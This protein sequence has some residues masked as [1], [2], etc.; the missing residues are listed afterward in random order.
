VDLIWL[1]C[2]AL[3]NWLLEIDGLNEAWT[4]EQVA[5]ST[6]ESDWLGELGDHDFDDISRD[7]VPNAI[8]RLSNNLTVRNFDSSG[9]GPGS[10]VADESINLFQMAAPSETVNDDCEEEENAGSARVVKNM[11]LT[12]FR[13][14]LV[15]HFHIMW[16]RNKIVWP[17]AKP[18]I[19]T[20]Q[21]NL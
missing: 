5:D 1:T 17:S 4:G 19:D 2:C 14:K 13:C 9:M 10:D 7:S 12:K 21:D 11:S 15:E 8:L 3:H 16:S 18:K 20:N 6:A